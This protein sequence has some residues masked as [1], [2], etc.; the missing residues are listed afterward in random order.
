MLQSRRYDLLEA[1][2]GIDRGGC[3]DGKMGP[4]DTLSEV[5]IEVPLPEGAIA[6]K[7]GN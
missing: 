2:D 3:L 7:V 4:S 1:R 6:R 5:V